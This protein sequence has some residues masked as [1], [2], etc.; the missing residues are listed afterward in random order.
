L[1]LSAFGDPS[2]AN[3]VG[4]PAASSFYGL[5]TTLLNPDPFLREVKDGGYA[6]ILRGESRPASW[7]LLEGSAARYH[8]LFTDRGRTEIGSTQ[9]LFV[10][11]VSGEW[12]G[13]VGEVL[14]EWRTRRHSAKGAATAFLGPHTVK[15]GLEFDRD[16]FVLVGGTAY[17]TRADEVG[18]IERVNDTTFVGFTE[19]RDKEVSDRIVHAY[20]QDSWQAT[21]WL[22]V[23]AGLRWATQSYI[24]VGDTIAQSFS[25]QW[26]PRLGLVVALGRRH[27]LSA[28]AGRYYLQLP[29]L[30]TMNSHGKGT[31][32]S[33]E[34]AW[35]QDPRNPPIVNAPTF[36]FSSAVEPRREGVEGEHADEV[37]VGYEGRLPGG[38]D[39]AT[40]GI[41]RALREAWG[42][43]FDTSAGAFRLGN[44]GRG[45]LAFLP[46][47]TR[48]HA[49]LEFTVLRRSS[50]PL[51]FLASYVLSRTHGNYSGIYSSGD[52]EDFPPQLNV[53]LELAE[54]ASNSTGLL[55]NDR[56]HVF[57]AAGSYGFRHGL[58]VGA[59]FTAQ[60][61][62]PLTDLGQSSL[63]FGRPV[64]L[65]E[66]GSAGRTPAVWDLDL[67]I[68]YQ[69]P[70][71]LLP[72]RGRI[73]LDLRN[74]GSPRTAVLLEQ[75]KFLDPANSVL[76]PTF[77]QAK[78]YQP[79]MSLRLG[80]EIGL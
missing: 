8:R 14:D 19:Y 24:G 41:Y 27:K 66:R 72:G 65:V 47:P 63:G 11:L 39:F 80:L 2:A 30:L 35:R 67:R 40:R 45:E 37:V 70:T 9:P 6:T 60:S 29:L 43:G 23:N 76:N 54:Q 62:I 79:P 4:N 17:V 69:W 33:C 21:D 15:G 31:V 71:G 50:S 5:P 3:E 34:H 49:A 48:R 26:Q 61:G 73:I 52:G 64:F 78:A 18:F 28:S 56:T 75:Y 59:F 22:V 25:T 51:S 10:D 74:V 32:V 46:R 44:L 68:S 20:L 58:S 16:L 1:E 36:C 55:P 38:L 57:K 42:A 53:A 7:L 12:S 13:G 77:G